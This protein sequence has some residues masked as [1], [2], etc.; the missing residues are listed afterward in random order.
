MIE[1]GEWYIGDAYYW[2]AFN[3]H[4]LQQLDLARDDIEQAKRVAG[5]RAEV[6]LLSGIIY[7]DRRELDAAAI[8]LAR[9]WQMN[10]LACDAAWYLGLVRSEQRSWDAASA[11]FPPA[12][13]CY[14]TTAQTYR[15]E[16]GQAQ[17]TAETDEE[18]AG[19]DAEYGR[20]IE[21][22]RIGEA[23]SYYNAAYAY[24]RLNDRQHA[25]A[26]AE[27]AE[28]HPSMKAKA[29]ELIDALKKTP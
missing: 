12:A 1:L 13:V 16:L 20:L 2:R 18:R 23:R 19:I 25:I 8:D 5:L 11:L 9:A 24:A 28:Q 22:Q 26:F 21:Q 6:F 27:R 14:A 15:A 7:F 29:A 3:R 4:E 17:K 10:D